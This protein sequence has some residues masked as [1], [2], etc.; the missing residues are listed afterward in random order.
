MCVSA[1]SS[2][3]CVVRPRCDLACSGVAQCDLAGPFQR[4]RLGDADERALER[5]AGQRLA[6]DRVL[7]RG[8]DQRQGRR[9]LAQVVPGELPG[10]DRG[11]GAVEDVVRDLER[12]AERE[13]EAADR[14]V[15]ASEQARGAEELRRLERAAP[16][17]LLFGRIRP[18]GL[19][20]LERLT[21]DESERGGGKQLHAL[22]V[23]RRRELG[24]GARVQVVARRA[25]TDR[26][27]RPPRG[28]VAA[29]ERRSIDH[30]VVHEARHV[31]ELDGCARRQRVVA[32]TSGE[33][34][35]QRSQPLSTC[36]ERLGAGL[37]DRAWMARDR[38]AEAILQRRHVRIEPGSLLDGS[39]RRA[40]HLASP[41]TR[42]TM[43]PPRRRCATGWKPAARTRSASS[44]G[45][46]NRR[47]LA[48]R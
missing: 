29:A 4:A 2:G 28:L 16:E 33:E 37:G 42:T 7:A 47:T 43:P 14:L 11:A 22:G 45:P 31:D 21:A 24:E 46:G 27:V 32:L 10:L 19:R 8:E 6:H 35:E 44:A 1:S 23:A 40:V 13:R 34:D 36:R 48:G 3:R 30:V 20:V 15:A 12:D 25:G 5:A 9:A 18:V 41:T 17:V 26:A 38:L 39:E